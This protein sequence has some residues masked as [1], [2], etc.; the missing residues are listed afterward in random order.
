MTIAV[1][2]ICVIALL[3]GVVV[4]VGAPYLP[5]MKPQV[6][7]AFTLLDLKKG[8]TLLELGCG[9]GRV[10]A[11]AARRGYRAVGIELNLVLVLV[12][13]WRTRQYRDRVRVIWGNYWLKPWPES[14][15]VFTFL[16]NKFM[17]TL[18]THMQR[19]GG[20]LVSVAFKIPGRQPVKELDSV[21]LYN[22]DKKLA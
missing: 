5:T 22:Y 16:I 4:F 10:L 12:A 3:F 2:I 1:L 8:Q 14:D 19:Y 6:A 20:K 18:D 21:Y 11:E 13:L 9:D 7:A 17:P 15:G